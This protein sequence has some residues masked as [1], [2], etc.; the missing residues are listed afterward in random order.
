MIK[1]KKGKGKFKGDILEVAGEVID[2]LSSENTEKAIQALHVATME[3]SGNDI[4]D[5]HYANICF[6][7]L[8][9]CAR[10]RRELD[11]LDEELGE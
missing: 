6:E 10:V 2:I 3:G 11:I 7:I 8:K 5:K 1:V 9:C 4:V